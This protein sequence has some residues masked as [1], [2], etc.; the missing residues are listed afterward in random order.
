MVLF[1]LHA[2]KQKQIELSHLFLDKG[3]KFLFT[4]SEPTYFFEKK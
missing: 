3:M 1:G 2:F 4:S